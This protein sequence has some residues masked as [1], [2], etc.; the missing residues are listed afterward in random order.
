MREGTVEWS[1]ALRVI[2]F[3]ALLGVVPCGLL[4]GVVVSGGAG[5]VALLLL[6][7]LALGSGAFYLRRRPFPLFTAGM[8]ARMGVVLALLLAVMLSVSSGVAGFVLRYGMHSKAVQDN[9]NI[10]LQQAQ[11]WVYG[12]ADPPPPEAWKVMEAPEV[13]AG[14]FVMG[15]VFTSAFMVVVGALAGA[16]A[17]AL[18]GAQQRRSRR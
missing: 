15:Q 4:P 2:L 11:A 16:A 7:L 6:P 18:L 1:L 10:A 3:A 8:G 5:V 13:R 14:I 9:L 17:G 12:V